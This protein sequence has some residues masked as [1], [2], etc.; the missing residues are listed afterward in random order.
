MLAAANR[1][2]RGGDC[3]ARD[4]GRDRSPRGLGA[5]NAEL[6]QGAAQVQQLTQ[7]VQ[8]L[9]MMIKQRQ[10]IEQ[11]KQDSETKRKLMEVTAKAHDI[12]M[13]NETKRRDTDAR[14]QVTAE[15]TAV[16]TKTQIDIE[17]IKGQFA[18]MLAEIDAKS[19][20]EASSETI[21]RAI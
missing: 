8:Q 7:Q 17:Y 14:V 3:R 5:E 12:E 2:T 9:Q 21:E 16:K 15:D 1:E 20:H 4:K 10:D 18:L 6:K 19:M 11:V 13:N